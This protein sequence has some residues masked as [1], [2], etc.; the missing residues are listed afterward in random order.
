MSLIMKCLT[1]YPNLSSEK[2]Y[3]PINITLLHFNIN[4]EFVKDFVMF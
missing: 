2:K 3:V 1:D 4:L